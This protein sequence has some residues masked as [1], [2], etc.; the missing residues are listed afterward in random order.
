LPKP[1]GAREVKSQLV[2][3]VALAAIAFVSAARV[4]AH[5]SDNV[6]PDLTRDALALL[7]QETYFEMVNA[8]MYRANVAQGSTDEDD[9][10]KRTYNHFLPNIYVAPLIGDGEQDDALS[11]CKETGNI[12]NDK[13]WP[14]AI[15]EYDYTVDAKEV[16]YGYLG[17]CLHLVEDMSVPAHVNKDKHPGGD[18]F[19]T[20]CDSHLLQLS[21]GSA[22]T[23]QATPDAYFTNADHDGAKDITA[24]ASRFDASLAEFNPQPESTFRRMFPSLAF[25]PPVWPFPKYWS[26][27]AVGSYA[28]LSSDE[29]WPCN[30]DAEPYHWDDGVLTC[31]CYVEN[32]GDAVPDEYLEEENGEGL[33][34]CELYAPHTIERCINLCAG[35]AKF[36][37]DIVNHPPYVD[38]VIVQQGGCVRYYAEWEDAVEG[39]RVTSCELDTLPS[40]CVD[41]QS[42]A[43][44]MLSFSEPVSNPSLKLTTN[45]GGLE[46]VDLTEVPQSGGFDWEGILTACRIRRGIFDGEH[47]TLGI[48]ATDRHNHHAEIGG[49]LDAK[50][51]TPAKRQ[52]T[53]PYPWSG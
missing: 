53:S 44:I 52:N 25:H 2:A 31:R 1:K 28:G 14:S 24:E 3:V 10:I 13:G 16:A 47:T 29:W 23:S 37:Y 21:N 42:D 32:A 15:D 6:H 33:T 4:R 30:W 12:T 27:T 18:E 11:W 49:Q 5:D 41:G 48:P 20:W 39:N 8:G 34:L 38:T 36:Y 43:T 7:P 50:P 51:D 40:E 35:M 26:I 46:T 9:P 45:T 19:E 22:V 17:E